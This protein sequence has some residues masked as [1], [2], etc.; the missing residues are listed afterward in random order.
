[1]PLKQKKQMNKV[2]KNISYF[3]LLYLLLIPSLSFS[4][5]SRY[6]G[7]Y[8]KS[9]PIEY[10]NKSN[11]V[12]EGMEFSPSNTYAIVLW[13]CKN[14]VI[15][16]CKFTSAPNI[17]AVYIEKGDNVTIVDCTFEDVY[18]GVLVERSTNNI[19]VEH[20]NFKNI[21]GKLDGGA[22]FATAVQFNRVSG[23]GNSISYNAIENIQG[24]SSP[25]DIINLFASN[26]TPS[27][28]IMVR[29]N[30]LRGGGPNL[31]GGGI[32]LGD[33][34]GSYQIAEKNILV[35]PGQYGMA[36]SGGHDMIIRDNKIY[37][38][39][40]SFTNVGLIATNW[41]P[42]LGNAYNITVERNQI[43]WTNK[44]GNI[45]T[46][47]S[48]AKKGEIIGWESNKHD[49]SLNESILPKDILNRAGK[50]ENSP[51]E[52]APE[53]E[54][55]TPSEPP[56]A[57]VYIDRFKRIVV[58]Y[59]APSI[60]NAYAEGYSSTG[61]LLITMALPRYNQAFPVSV[62]RGDYYIKIVY[63]TLGKEEITKI[64]IN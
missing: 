2:I 6:T 3:V 12:I 63:P 5:G 44:D 34:G 61:Q 49:A 57:Q 51:D 25:E 58:K 32:N 17:R 36:I 20:N 48:P 14:V 47:W 39:R 22:Y 10:V 50:T 46:L 31:S 40:Q 37:G 41:T 62:P 28:P 42:N 18:E 52:N 21:R 26:G 59:L 8:K 54:Q 60:P 15:K 64:T 7:S 38:K 11:I 24:Q 23:S 19:K 55:P 9:S 45:N 43:N 29:E 27:S 56:I 16:N 33:H 30:W 13:N 4:Q 1:M 53:I 35:N